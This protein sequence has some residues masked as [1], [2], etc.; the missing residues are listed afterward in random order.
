MVLPKEARAIVLFSHGSGSDRQSTRN[1]YVADILNGS[2]FATLLID[3]LTRDEKE[4]DNRNHHLRFDVD[5]LARRLLNVTQWIMD[6]PHTRGLLLG[7]FASST[8]AAAAL[9]DAAKLKG[10][11]KAVVSRGGRPDLADYKEEML[12]YVTA[13]TLLIVGGSDTRSVIAINKSALKRLSAASS[14]ELAIIPDAGHLFE[15]QG[16]MEQV[17]RIST[18]WFEQHLLNDKKQ[19]QNKY[20]GDKFSGR[21]SRLK[22]L[23][24]LYLRFKD[25]TAAGEIL[26]STLKKYKNEDH[27][28]DI[29]VIGIPRGGVIVADVVARALG[30]AIDIIVSKRLRV[31][32]NSENSLGAIMQDGSTYFDEARIRSLN[33]SQEYLE[34]E[35][36]EQQKEIR[37]KLSLYRP[38]SKEYA[39]RDRT[40]VLVD[41][42]AATGATLVA[43]ARWTRKQQPYKVIIAVPVASRNAAD[44][45]KREADVL[46]VIRSP[47]NFKSVENYYQDFRSVSDADVIRTLG[48]RTA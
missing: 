1:R 17:A 19:F 35:K 18:E 48:K 41:D 16:K 13:P 21:L 42:G 39:I 45:L 10:T 23:P 27:E 46:E 11:V 22:E 36:Q 33:I 20:R 8:G 9:I 26:S 34:A 25:R 30:G 37:R 38:S 14:R 44:A 3:L 7:Y 12:Q 15:E 29:A 40:V 47:S 31:P 43:A 28:H 6:Q 2:G 4:L 24:Q 5:L 32:D